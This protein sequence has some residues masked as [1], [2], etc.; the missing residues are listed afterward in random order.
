[1]ETDSM[2]NDSMEISVSNL[3]QNELNEEQIKVVEHVMTKKNVLITGSAGTGKSFLIKHLCKQFDDGNIEYAILA[4][5]G[6]A[7]LNVLGQTIHRFFGIRPDIKTLEDYRRLCM[8]RSKVNWHTL[9]III[10]DEI[11]MVHPK[12][13]DLF[14]K[15]SRYHLKSNLPFGG[16]QMIFLGDFFQLCPIRDRCDS[17]EDPSYVFETELWKRMNLQVHIL[18]K[19]MRQNE[20]DFIMMLND[21]RV[22]NLSDESKR[23][24]DTC[25][26]NKKE[27][28]KHYVC[29]Y[30]LNVDKNNANETQ[31]NKLDTKTKIY[32]AQ[33]TGDE[34]LL[35]GCRAEKR[36][37]L[38]IG[39]PVMLLWN[40]PEM[41]LCNGSIGILESYDDDHY[42][43]VFFNN[44]V[45]KTV[46]PQTW[47][48]KEKNRSGMHILASRSQIPLAVAY[49]LSSH[50]SQGLTIDHLVVDVRNV[51]TTGQL[52][53]MLSRASTSGNLIIK[54]FDKRLILT[55]RKV[56]GFYQNNS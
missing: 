53:V 8:K 27:P 36:I 30:S 6:V 2:K 40:M 51:F 43:V 24:I 39:C 18:K 33:D 20:Q 29:L 48:I 34:K 4:P 49:A 5:T 3:I 45:K 12:L 9:K 42:P 13:F 14:D 55:D 17:E 23:V 56:V 47:S 52:Y 16:L 7:A 31:L 37:M 1:M 26:T 46:V 35:Q 32:E 38:K 41:N 10:I 19:V 28:G 25:C 22:G 44:G 15:I 54:N 21:L 11:S 50:K